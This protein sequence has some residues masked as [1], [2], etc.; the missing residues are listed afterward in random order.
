MKKYTILII[1][2][3]IILALLTGIYV[4]PKIQGRFFYK[5]AVPQAVSISDIIEDFEATTEISLEDLPGELNLDAPFYPQAPFADWGYPWQEACEE[6]SLLLVVNEYFNHNWTREEFNNEILELVE[7]EKKRFGQ[8]EH[9]N[10]YE[11]AQIL[12][13]YFGLSSVIHEDPTLEDVKL[14]LGKGHLIVMTFAGRELGNPF[15]TGEGP[16]YHAMTIKGYKKG[17][18][19]IVHDVGTRNGENYVYDW[20]TIYNALHDYAEPIQKGSKYM[21][22]VIPPQ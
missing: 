10:N 2:L 19:L 20:S 11:T 17:D 18:K 5:E 14:A 9:T 1:E 4:V 22:E 3:A 6:A 15:Y 16:I 13:E 12:K 7:W 8:Y 21:I